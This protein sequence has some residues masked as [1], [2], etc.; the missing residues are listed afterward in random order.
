MLL[1]LLLFLVLLSPLK[2]YC[3]DAMGLSDDIRKIEVSDIQCNRQSADYYGYVRGS[4]P[5][6]IS[7]PHGAKH[8]RTSENRWK[9]E[10][11]YTSSWAVKLGRLTGA[12]VLYVKNKT[13]EDPNNDPRSR[14]KDFLEKVV[15]ESGVR[16]VIDLHGADW[17]EPFKID[18]GTIDNRPERS[19]CPTF[20]AIIEGAFRDFDTGVFNKRFSAGKPCTITSFARN[21]LGIEAAQFE[22]NARY[23]IMKRGA[24]PDSEAHEAAVL[25]LMGRFQGMI[26]AID[27]KIADDASVRSQAV[28]MVHETHPMFVKK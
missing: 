21:T 13:A 6:L 4:I 18:V 19:S 10:D 15:K 1:A 2:G 23:R 20:K 9:A 5:I 11:A 14:Y 28:S 7:A 25:D 17:D 3:G 27:R 16:F 8:Y 24:N 12:H 26:M 22:I